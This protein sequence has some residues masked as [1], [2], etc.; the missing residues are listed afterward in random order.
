MDHDRSAG[1][2]SALQLTREG[3]LTEAVAVLQ[4]TLGAPTVPPA[5]AHAGAAPAS[6]AH[7]PTPTASVPS[8][9]LGRLRR[10]LPQALSG[11][12]PPDP[13]ADTAAA[14]SE[15]ILRLSH[16][17]A[18]GTR[19]FDLY[20]PT[21]RTGERRP[22]VI[23]LHGGSQNAADFAA[24]TRMN[25][26]AERHGLLVAYPEQPTTA[27][28]GGYWNWFS[29][30]DQRAG[31]GEPS[32]LS[33]IT[34]W[35]IDKY[36]ADPDRVYVAG[37]S[38]G[39]AMAA[40]M[41]ATYPDLYA[42]VGVHSG[43]AYGTA[44]DVGSAFAAMRTGGTPAPGGD[45]PLIVFHGDGDTLVAPVNAERLIAARLAAAGPGTRGTP[46]TIRLTEP[47]RRP[48][49]RTVVHDASGVVVAESWSIH[50][51][52]HAWSGGDPAAS[53]T[54]PHGPDASTQMVRFFLEHPRCAR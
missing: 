37:L 28:R 7:V 47:G 1:M 46:T 16:T 6:A 9:L 10:A 38:A 36:N 25:E 52:G 8:G 40:V 31:E 2:A 12:R 29:P 34:R 13:R 42:A 49:T 43:I 44:H 51:A 5:G 32:I 11:V 4:R 27:N 26:L 35:I 50:G 53:Y 22:L 18:A 14:A 23:M 48:C 19:R 45:L 15:R 3:R 20:V 30:A 21:D 24:G 41:A 54:D 39:G 33:G 17:E